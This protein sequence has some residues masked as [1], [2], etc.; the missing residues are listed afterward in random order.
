MARY[1]KIDTRIWSDQKFNEMSDYGKLVFFMVLT[2]PHLTAL[3]AM[4]ATIPGLATELHWT[5]DKL[6]QALGESFLNKMVIF[7]EDAAL[8]WLPNFIKYNQPESPNV[9]R[10][11]NHSLDYLPECKLKNTLIEKINLYISKLS[12]PF[13][14]ALPEAFQKISPNQEQEQEQKHNN[15][16]SG[17]PDNSQKKLNIESKYN[18]QLIQQAIEVL[19]FLNE[20]TQRKYRIVDTNLRRVIAR[21]KS[22]VTVQE[23]RQIIAKKTRDWKKDKKMAPYLRPATLFNADKF[24]QYLGELVLPDEENN[25]NAK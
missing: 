23:C 13:Q 3:G 8:M 7:D 15:I 6:K 16:L 21:L 4:R 25:S 10:S 22:G 14:E 2:H 18:D 24:E 1:R 11:W 9:V 20:K 17:K 19:N 5:V 12:F